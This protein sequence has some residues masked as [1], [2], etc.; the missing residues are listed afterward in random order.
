MQ[1]VRFSKIAK[2]RRW[3]AAHKAEAPWK[4][5]SRYGARHLYHDAGTVLVGGRCCANPP[6]KEIA[7]AP[8][9]GHTDLHADLRDGI[10]TCRQQV[11]CLIQ[12]R[13]DS[14]LVR[15]KP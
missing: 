11:F 10:L 7:E 12:A 1:R 14:K 3:E 8:Q 13:P 5:V 4:K 15:R 2:R 9:A 6:Y